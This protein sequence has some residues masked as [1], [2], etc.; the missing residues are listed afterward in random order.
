MSVTVTLEFP[1]K[2]ERVEEFKAL[3]NDLLVDTRAFEGCQ[4]VD[5]YQD[6]ERPGDILLVEDWASKNHQQ[7]Y[8]AWRD[9]IGTADA[10]GPFL[11]SAIRFNY[12]DQVDI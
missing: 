8:Q 12:F 4:R 1:I 2:P 10:I 3:L 9:E 11:A 7:K 5:V 6:Q